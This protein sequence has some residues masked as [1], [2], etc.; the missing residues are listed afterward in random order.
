M[1]SGMSIDTI[2]RTI[3]RAFTAAGLDPH[4]GVPGSVLHTI[5]H[6]LASAHGPGSSTGAR[7]QGW[8][9]AADVIDAECRV[10]DDGSPRESPEFRSAPD[11]NG[12]FQSLAYT[13]SKGRRAY[14]LYVPGSLSRDTPA[15]LLVML[16]GCK[17]DPDDFARGTRMNE[18]AEE[19]GFLVAYPCQSRGDNGSNCWRWFE[20]GQQVRDGAEPSII[21][22][23]VCEICERHPVDR[24]RVYVAGLS[25]GAAMAVILGETYPDVFAAVGAHS[26][27]PRGAAHD[28]PSAFV[29]M[30][31]VAL[32][33]GS[34]SQAPQQVRGHAVPTIV[35]HG[36]ADGTVS[37][38]NGQAITHRVQSRLSQERGPLQAQVAHRMNN[39]RRCTVTVYVDAGGTPLVEHWAVQGAGH[40]WFGGSQAGSYSVSDG[41]CSSRELI[42]FLLLHANR[43]AQVPDQECAV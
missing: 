35:F 19:F 31:G 23:I 13:C 9:G 16:H 25:A 11:G 22:G 40:A 43:M 20:S 30:R 41:P 10:V 39:G 15:P 27:L 36:D 1:I 4:G 26:G 14:K 6:T 3:E 8:A 32:A 7:P 28:V 37:C 29:A 38:A 17:Q 12:S 5:R 18:I 42:R 34:E 2:S 33:P 24:R 21:A